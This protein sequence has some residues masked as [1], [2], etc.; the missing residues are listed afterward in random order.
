MVRH[1]C[2]IF[3]SWALVVDIWYLPATTKRDSEDAIQFANRVKSHIAKQGGLVDTEWD[4]LW[5]RS[6]PKLRLTQQE[7]EKYTIEKGLK[8]A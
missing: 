5:K 8:K 7:Q 6:K 4:G 2:N 1:L 3:T